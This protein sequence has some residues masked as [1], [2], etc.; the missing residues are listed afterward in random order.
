MPYW[1]KNGCLSRYRH[2]RADAIDTR[3]CSF[4]Y[5]ISCVIQFLFAP[6]QPHYLNAAPLLFFAD[7]LRVFLWYLRMLRLMNRGYSSGTSENHHAHVGIQEKHRVAPQ[8][9]VREI[10]GAITGTGVLS[11][12]S[13]GRRAPHA[14]LLLD[15]IG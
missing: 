7:S 5:A 1:L 3:W 10:M 9:C 4:D 13:L 11:T 12:F 6:S 14:I 8:K 2:E 15:D